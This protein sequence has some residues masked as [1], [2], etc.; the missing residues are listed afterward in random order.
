MNRLKGGYIDSMSIGYSPV[1][2]EMESSDTARWGE[3]RHLKEV[4]LREV[5]LVLWPMNP[6]ARINLDSVKAALS[7]IEDTK[8]LRGLASH[9]GSLLRNAPPEESADAPKQQASVSPDATPGAPADSPK[10]PDEKG[11]LFAEAV[12]HRLQKLLL[13]PKTIAI[14]RNEE[15]AA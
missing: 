13:D 14:I 6:G 15:N 5:S 2:W 11:Y 8:A 10:A 12:G 1:K 4:E 9:I 3:I 7:T